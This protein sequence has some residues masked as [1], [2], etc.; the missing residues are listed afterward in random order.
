MEVIDRGLGWLWRVAIL[1]SL[2][3][4]VLIPPMLLRL[5]NQLDG[6][7]EMGGWQVALVVLYFV[8][9]GLMILAANATMR[10]YTGEYERPR[11]N[12]QDWGLI[13]GSYLAIIALESGFELVNRLV[14]HQTQTQNNAAI[15]DLMAGSPI[16][17]WMMA[18]SAVFLTPIVE[19]LVFRGVL[20]NL[21]F[22]REWL[23]VL[24]SGLVFGSLHS[25]STLPSFL[26]YVMMGLIL[27]TVYRLSGKISAAII[28][29]FIINLAA[30][31]VMV[32]QLVT[33]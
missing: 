25:S 32:L 14:Y 29:H 31:S 30:M 2:I 16:A 26:I 33:T 12:R 5:I 28:L 22:K 6:E 13:I 17:L 11:L 4:G 19:E 21:F 9:F 1:V 8:V 27:A 3:I 18:I 15:I 7:W 23:K 10:H 24:L 20:T